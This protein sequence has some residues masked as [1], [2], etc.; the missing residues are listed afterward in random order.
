MKPTQERR[1]YFRHPCYGIA[2]IRLKTG[3]YLGSCHVALVCDIGVKGMCLSMDRPMAVGAQVLITVRDKYEFI[4]IVCH[5]R[6]VDRESIL[7]IRFSTGEWNE[8]SAW[9]QRRGQVA[10]EE[11][12]RDEFVEATGLAMM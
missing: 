7:N 12:V 1:R 2:D 4:G 9:P 5:V 3:S 11:G 6:Q 8:Q 10:M